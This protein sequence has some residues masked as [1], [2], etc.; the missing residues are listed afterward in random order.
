M[1]VLSTLVNIIGLCFFIKK[2]I[3]RGSVVDLEIGQVENPAPVGQAAQAGLEDIDEGMEDPSSPLSTPPPE[4]S[5]LT[6]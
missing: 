6:L 4:V 2:M 3:K 5:K 1:V